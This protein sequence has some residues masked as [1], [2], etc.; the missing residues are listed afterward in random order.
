MAIFANGV[1]KLTAI[2]TGPRRQWENRNEKERE[3][4]RKFHPS[5]RSPFNR[6]NLQ[7]NS[8]M[9]KGVYAP[10]THNSPFKARRSS[11]CTRRSPCPVCCQSGTHLLH[12]VINVSD[13]ALDN[14][15]CVLRFRFVEQ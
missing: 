14:D 1:M 3:P 2:H 12:N 8:I 10:A 4:K 5:V 15:V 11:F 6:M 9:R 7:A 13:D